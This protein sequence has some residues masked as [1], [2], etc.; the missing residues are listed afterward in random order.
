[1]MDNDIKAYHK[2]EVDMYGRIRKITHGLLDESRLDEGLYALG[3]NTC[4][5]SIRES[6]WEIKCTWTKEKMD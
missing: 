3:R 1:M 5:H 6:M 4:L 2:G